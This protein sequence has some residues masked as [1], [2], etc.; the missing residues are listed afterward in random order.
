M[1]PPQEAVF[2]VLTYEILLAFEVFCFKLCQDLLVYVD[3]VLEDREDGVTLKRGYD[4]LVVDFRDLGAASYGIANFLELKEVDLSESTEEHT[5]NS[6]GDLCNV[7]LLLF[8]F[9]VEAL[10]GL[11]KQQIDV[12]IGEDLA[13]LEVL[14]F[15]INICLRGGH[16]EASV[17]HG[18]WRLELVDALNRVHFLNR[19]RVEIENHAVATLRD[20]N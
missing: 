10:L 8:I 16:D 15:F 13:T 6:L 14:S 7:D 18:V 3:I 1:Q 5:R 2:A 17:D 12:F 19:C 20:L 11:F 4:R 9:S